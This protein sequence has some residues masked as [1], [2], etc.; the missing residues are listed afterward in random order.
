MITAPDAEENH[1]VN[2][3]IVDASTENAK[4]LRRVALRGRELCALF[5]NVQSS[6]AEVPG[7]PYRTPPEM[8][9][10]AERGD[11]CQIFGK[12]ARG[13]MGGG[14]RG[15]RFRP[16]RDMAVEV[17]LESHEDRPELFPVRRCVG[18]GESRERI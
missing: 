9:A 16:R 8:P 17:L 7:T 4:R 15:T 12:I 5:I 6:L 2:A 18:P 13:G 11:R 3:N 14:P 10:P 1:D